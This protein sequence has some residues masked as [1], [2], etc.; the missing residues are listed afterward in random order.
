MGIIALELAQG[1][2]PFIEYPEL[3]ALFMITSSAPASLDNT[4]SNE[5][6][7]FV[8]NCLQKESDKRF[9]CEELLQQP[10]I[11]KRSG[12]AE[13]MERIKATLQ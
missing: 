12:R 10:F 2:P 9:N 4:W 8:T 7:A 11:S 3:K 1:H 6:Q 13:I 5:F